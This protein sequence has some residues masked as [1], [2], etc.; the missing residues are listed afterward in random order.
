MAKMRINLSVDQEISEMLKEMA[1]AWHTTVSQLITNWTMERYKE[2]K[3]WDRLEE[4]HYI[5]GELELAVDDYMER[6]PDAD[7]RAVERNPD[8]LVDLLRGY[9]CRV[10]SEL[11]EL[12]LLPVNDP[13]NP[14]FG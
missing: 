11:A 2:L 4:T 3:A 8:L 7:R 13:E 1:K 5:P 12:G 10:N 6:H 9:R 14:T